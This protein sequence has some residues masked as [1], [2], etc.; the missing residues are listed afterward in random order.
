MRSDYAKADLIN[1][2]NTEWIKKVLVNSEFS[3]PGP[4]DDDDDDHDDHRHQHH[5]DVD[6]DSELPP[7]RDFAIQQPSGPENELSL[8]LTNLSRL[9]HPEPGAAKWRAR[10]QQPR[11]VARRIAERLILGVAVLGV[12]VAV[13]V[14]PGFQDGTDVVLA[15]E[16]NTPSEQ[17]AQIDTTALKSM[18][19][20]WL[21]PEILYATAITPARGQPAEAPLL[22]RLGR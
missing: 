7:H 17:A 10:R 20:A 8:L 13:W 6:D 3:D 1:K 16:P 11:S 15:Q 4:A 19:P 22:P 9:Q 2:V 14:A 18:E 21:S 5:D 12:G